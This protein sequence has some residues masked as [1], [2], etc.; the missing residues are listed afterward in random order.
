[1]NYKALENY[2]CAQSIM[3]DKNQYFYGM[4]P[5]PCEDIYYSTSIS[6]VLWPHHSTELSFYK[7]YI[8]DDPR[9]GNQFDEYQHELEI[10]ENITDSS[11]LF[12]NLTEKPGLETAFFS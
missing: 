11:S 7:T 5:F 3:A 6:S 2:K 4:C 12:T 8:A 9:F 1:M 10:A